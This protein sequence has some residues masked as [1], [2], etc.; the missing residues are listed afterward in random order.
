M[1]ITSLTDLWPGQASFSPTC[2]DSAAADVIGQTLAAGASTSC[3]FIVDDYAPPIGESLIDTVT[4]IVADVDDS[5]N[6]ATDM[7]DSTVTTNEPPVGR[8]ILLDIVK[9]NDADEDGTFTDSEV[10]DAEGQAVEFQVVITN[11]SDITVVI[12]SLTDFWLGQPQFSPTCLDSAAA[13]VIGQTL[14]PDASTTCTFTVADYAP[15]DGDSLVDVVAVIVADVEDATKTATDIDP[16]TVSTPEPPVITVNIVKTNDADGDGGYH[17]SEIAPAEGADVPF[18]AIITN[19]SAV[20]VTIT[21]LTDLLPGNVVADNICAD[22]IG[23]VLDPGDFVTCEWIESG[24]AGDPA[25]PAKV[26]TATVVVCAVTHPAICG[27]D[28]DTSTVTTTTPEPPVI[29]VNI[30]KTND[31]DGDDEYNDSEVAPVEGADVPF[32]AV[33][34][35]TSAVAVTITSLTDLLPGHVIADDICAGLIGTVLQPNGVTGDSVTCDWIEEDYA[36]DPTDPAKVNTATVVVC[37]VTDPENCGDDDDTSTVT[38]PP[39]PVITVNIVK[40]NDASGDGQYNDSEVA[41][42]EG[43]DVPFRAVITNTS[44]VAVTIT[45]LTD[46]LPGNDTA[47][48]VCADL[49]GTV[50]APGGSATCEWIEPG[51]AGDPTDPAKVNT[52][53][54]V[55]CA[56]THPAICGVDD[57]TS[58]VTTP[59]PEPPVIT[60]NIVKTND[61]NGDGQYNDSEVAPAEGA[62]VPFRAV[63]TNTS[64]VAV[65]ITSLTD[66]LPGNVVADNICADLIGTVLD[67][68]GSVTCNWIEPDYAGDPDD[69]AKVNT[70]TVVVCPV[71]DPDNCGDDDDTSTVTTPPVVI[72]L[73]VDKTNDGNGDGTFTDDETG[74]AGN[75]VTFRVTVTNT[76][77]VA[78][79][80][81]SISDVW[82][83]VVA[84]QPECEA[85]FI[86]VTLAPGQSLTCQFTIANYVP[87]TAQGAKVNS[88]TVTVLSGHRS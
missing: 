76:S 42:A 22:L 23:T 74:T 18:R 46:L 2:L 28:D 4:V 48:D 57:D 61:A 34:T 25:D 17:D 35:N 11:P 84:F 5:T 72:S 78:V 10:A 27:N 88:A 53:T 83:G 8:S 49:I 37:P 7:D 31:A 40:T 16:S 20:A 58:T 85:Q 77:S 75:P 3:T 71:T 65:T 56:V 79:V 32:R 1:V 52:A 24:Y 38:T 73:V 39:P 68:G 67:P 29:T 62:D 26:N 81:D 69:P 70:A 44:A 36:G 86:G 30:E 64:A 41:P 33:I 6:T 9:T 59:N 47:D 45:S 82:P 14:A 63:I 60:V 43:A 15:P 51:Y 87:T 66:L 50:L 19:T 54:V 55:V 80:I 13:N 12:T 21:S